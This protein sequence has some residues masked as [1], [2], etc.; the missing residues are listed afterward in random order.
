MLS[1]LPSAPVSAPESAPSLASAHPAS[2]DVCD[3]LL[4]EQRLYALAA[5]PLAVYFELTET[6]APFAGTTSGQGRG[7]QATW[8]IRDGR[9]YLVAL[10]GTL[11]GG[12]A[13]SLGDVFP[14][15]QKRVF[16]H[17]FSGA[18]HA[19]SPRT[20]IGRV[21][22]DG[23][24]ARLSDEALRFEI[25]SGVV[26]PALPWAASLPTPV[27]PASVSPSAPVAAAMPTREVAA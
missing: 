12:R 20:A 19:R 10:Q 16:A 11:A 2:F 22:L 8:E 21:V 24:D 23:L 14:A 18:L 25:E 6:S 26:L 17:W 13:G 27:R 7:Y 3:A 5:E 1:P 9:L 15:F 4:I